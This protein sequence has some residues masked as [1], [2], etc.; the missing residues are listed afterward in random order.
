MN[1]GDK[2]N[3]VV[4][5]LLG[6]AWMIVGLLQMLSGDEVVGMLDMVV[7]VGNHILARSY[8]K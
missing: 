2:V 3:Y 4:Y 8:E 1:K 5:W 6:I 7:A